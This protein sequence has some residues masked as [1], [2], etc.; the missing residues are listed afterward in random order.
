MRYSATHKADTRK[1]LLQTAASLSKQKGFS[2][3]GVDA[4]VAAAGL[5]SG[6]FYNHFS[7]KNELFSELLKHEVENGFFMF[8]DKVEGES[9]DEWI[10]R[11]LKSYLNWG[12]VQHPES[13]CVASSLG[14]EIARAD[15]PTRKIFEAAARRVHGVWAEQ[16]GD[17]KA[18][19]AA[20]A[21]MIGTI[22]LA[23]AMAS[24]KTRRE[25]LNA[26]KG[27]LENALLHKD[28]A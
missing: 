22:V 19:W 11:Q 15:K 14:A 23:R 17:D 27:F 6:A 26:G 25:V 3:T 2:I 24:D 12:H 1:H 10:A 5:T 28:S 13:G 9:E 21:Q 7:S 20:I 16:V 4:L 8:V 18:A